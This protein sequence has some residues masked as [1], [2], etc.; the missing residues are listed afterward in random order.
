[1]PGS[2]SLSLWRRS[3]VMDLDQ[4]FSV[5][6]E[7]LYSKPKGYRGLLA[8]P[9][10][11]ISSKTEFICTL[12]VIGCLHIFKMDKKCFSLSKFTLGEK[13]DSQVTNNILN[14]RETITDVV[15]FTW[16]SDH[17]LAVVKKTGIVTMIDI[18]SGLE[19]QE[20][21]RVYS[22]PVLERANQFQGT[23]FLLESMSAEGR[24]NLSNDRGRGDSHCVEQITEDSFN[25]FDLSKL[26]WNMITFSKR[27]IHEMYDIL[28]SNGRYKAALDFADCHGLDKDEVIKSQWLHSA[29]GL[30]EINTYLSKIRDQV[31]ILSECVDKVGPTEDSVKALLEYGLRLTNQYIFSEK[32]DSE[33]TQ[34]WDFRVARLKI[35]QFRDRLETYLGINMGR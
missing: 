33:S 31:F 23:L 28:V 20:N 24:D 12:D 10:V 15:D 30:N 2:C 34:I 35:L 21:D 22:M 9:K 27:S 5:R 13:C 3:N 29:Q 7:G 1:M 8:Y 32:Q 19:V 18:R 4:L 25:N 16:W 6:F 11:Q 26:S 14:G 17:V